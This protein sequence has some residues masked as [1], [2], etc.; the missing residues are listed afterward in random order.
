MSEKDITNDS[1]I[2]SECIINTVALQRT[3]FNKMISLNIV[4]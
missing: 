4:C 1:S 3:I 2:K